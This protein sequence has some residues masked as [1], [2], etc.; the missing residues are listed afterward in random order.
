[1]ILLRNLQ[2]ALSTTPIPLLASE[3]FL[4]REGSDVVSSRQN[5]LG[6]T[7]TFR[8]RVWGVEERGPTKK[9]PGKGQVGLRDQCSGPHK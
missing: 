1:M 7:E 4:S 5:A 3:P 2:D 8:C 6:P 9:G